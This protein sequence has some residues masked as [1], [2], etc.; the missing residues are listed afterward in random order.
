MELSACLPQAGIAKLKRTDWRMRAWIIIIFMVG[1]FLLLGSSADSCGQNQLSKFPSGQKKVFVYTATKFGVPILK[2]II[3]ME[4]DSIHEGKSLLQI[5][6]S[7]RSLQYLKP[8][9]RMNN[10]FTSTMEMDTLS[11]IRYVKE[12]DQGGLLIGNKTYHQTLFFDPLR[13][14]VVVEKKG[15]EEKEEKEERFLPPSTYDPLSMFAR[16]YLKEELRPGEDIRMSI[17][18][19]VKL[20]EIVFHSKKE[21]IK[22]SK[23][24]EVEAVRLE[25]ATSFSTFGDKE[26]IIRIWYTEDGER[27]PLL[28]ELDL[29]VGDVKFELESVE[30]G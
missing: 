8:F 25:S 14:K 28:I 4:N 18:D 23:Y 2:G 26:G 20:R 17:F 13:Q 19:G 3:Q 5:N 15:K 6:A 10:H 1:L 22:S 27:A 16:C 29:P 24:G 30:K 7:F 11:P 21:K 12:V 9:F